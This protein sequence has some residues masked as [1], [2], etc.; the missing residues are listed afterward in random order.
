MKFY[1][2][3]GDL[4]EGLVKIPTCASFINFVP[5]NCNF[6]RGLSYKLNEKYGREEIY[7]NNGQIIT[8]QIGTNTYIFH[9]PVNSSFFKEPDYIM[10]AK[11][12]KSLQSKI[13]LFGVKEIIVYEEAQNSKKP[14]VLKTKVLHKYLAGTLEKIHYIVKPQIKKERYLSYIL[15][16]RYF[17]YIYFFLERSLHSVM[18]ISRS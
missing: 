9:I 13:N 10:T 6:A 5:K 16:S 8:Q 17:Y 14:F 11:M 7:L 12:L 18:E 3:E 4:A 1:I 15:S 2:I